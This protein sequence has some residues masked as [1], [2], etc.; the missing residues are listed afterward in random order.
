MSEWIEVANIDIRRHIS[1]RIEPDAFSFDKKHGYVWLQ[2]ACFSILRRLGCY[3]QMESVT[4]TRHHVGHEGRAFM[5]RL[6][7][8]KLSVFRYLE[9]EPKTLLIGAE[10]FQQLMRE[11]APSNVSFSFNS[12][13]NKGTSVIGLQV[14]VIPW[15]RGFVVVP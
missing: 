2:R 3:A 4:V 5:D 7:A 12:Q 1:V 10:D 6:Y 9:R 15:M 8:S 13:Y 14:Q 11:A